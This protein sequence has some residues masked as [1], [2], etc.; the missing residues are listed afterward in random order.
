[1]K[2]KLNQIKVVFMALTTTI[3]LACGGGGTSIAPPS[4]PN[5]APLMVDSGFNGVAHN[6]PFVTITICQPG[7]NNCQTIDHILVD[8]GST[9]IK[10]SQDQLNPNLLNAL[11]TIQYQNSPVYEC[12]QFGAGYTFGLG[13][14]VDVKIAGE[15][16]SNMPIQII[17]S[18]PNESVPVSCSSHSVPGSL[19]ASGA[20][21]IIGVNPASNP[22][23]DYV[24][25]TYTYDADNDIYTEI[26]DPTD[27]STM[28]VVNPVTGFAVDNNGVILSLPHV[29]VAQAESLSGYLIF[30]LNTQANNQVSSS[31][32]KVLGSPNN[33]AAIFKANTY[34]I[35]DTH[36]IFDSGTSHNIFYDTSIAPCYG[37]LEGLYCPSNSPTN[38]IS[39]IHSYDSDTLIQIVNPVVNY[40]SNPKIFMF[41]VVP[42]LSGI[43]GPFAMTM[44]GLPVFYGRNIYVGFQGESGNMTPLGVGPAWGFVNN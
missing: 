2:Y 13:A 43:T 39:N 23:N 37:L 33:Y 4:G 12:F 17:S 5:V 8:T 18:I 7:T 11:P 28:L 16:A 20:R 21:G 32:A 38:W 9:G 3:L 40:M 19:A 14:T 26:D 6:V 42:G 25:Y 27:I 34:S 15:S 41:D 29:A 10:I 1:M 31:V 36:S 30:G 22:A 24:N 35:N 44:Y